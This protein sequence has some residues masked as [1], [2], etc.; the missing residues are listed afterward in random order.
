MQSISQRSSPMQS[1]SQIKAPAE[2]NRGFVFTW[3][4][5]AYLA[6]TIF[7]VEW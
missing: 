6:S 2:T 1:I 5:F 4:L 3:C 7:L